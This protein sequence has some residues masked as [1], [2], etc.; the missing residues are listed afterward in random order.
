MSVV[1][2]IRCDGCKRQVVDGRIYLPSQG[3]ACVS[4]EV[5]GGMPQG[6]GKPIRLLGEHYCS[7]GCL[8]LAIRGALLD[9]VNGAALGRAPVDDLM[10]ADEPPKIVH[11]E[12]RTT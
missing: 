8:L 12:P 10:K 6:P 9:E 4:V 11:L 2:A 3:A 5:S 7:C 1:N